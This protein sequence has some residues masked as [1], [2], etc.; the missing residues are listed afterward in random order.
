MKITNDAN[1][2]VKKSSGTSLSNSNPLPQESDYTTLKGTECPGLQ[3]TKCLGQVPANQIIKV[4]ILLN[5]SEALPMT[6]ADK[7]QPLTHSDF[8]QKYGAASKDMQ[9]VRQF[10]QKNHL[11]IMKTDSA[12]RTLVLEGKASDLNQ[13]FGIQMNRYQDSKGAQFR[14]YQGNLQIPKNLAGKVIGVFGLNDRPIVHPYIK[15][16][17]GKPGAPA[18]GTGPVSGPLRP[19]GLFG[20]SYNAPQVA[21]MYNFP[22][23]TDGSGQTIGII[24]FGG[25][26]NPSDLQT[27]FQQ[28][29]IPMPN[30]KSVSVDGATNQPTGNANGPDGEVD[31]DIEVAGAD[32]PK[33]NI[34]VYFAPNSN[35]GFIDA[36]NQAIH[37]K[38]NHPNVISVS[39][40]GDESSWDAQ[41]MNSLNS[42]LKDAAALGITVC[43]ASGDNSASDGTSGKSVDFPAS[44]PY[45][46]GCGGTSLQA[47]SAGTQI[48]S[49]TAWGDGTPTDSGSGGGVS[50][51]FPLPSWQQAAKANIPPSPTQAGGRGVPDV[52]SDADPNTGYNVV[53]DGQQTV[54][55]GTSASAPMWAALIARLN[56]GLGSNVG[57]VNPALYKIYSSPTLYKEAFH[58]IT[59]G[60]NGYPAGPGW[61]P[62]TGLGSPN[63][64]GLLAAL[65][66]VESASSS[67]SAISS[68]AESKSKELSVVG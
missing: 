30:I 63:G 43:A 1:G 40:G 48:A 8:E 36:F 18:Q 9:A 41:T 59:Q 51:D 42:I 54:V 25:G 15:I 11:K 7:F 57:F 34:V 39:W 67:G 23:G 49:E 17:S 46:L 64:Q 28:L 61:D 32:A 20:T 24:E 21:Q 26:Y 22:K 12:A 44:D 35:Q 6:A 55:G 14:A 47:N 33:A 2:S 38:V 13:A 3:K 29:G 66:Q 62:V 52:A 19:S 16:L 31:L 53:I 37:D 10:A 56:Q 60:S 58:D 65:K 50:S 4:S 45:V 27:Y 68:N 5:R